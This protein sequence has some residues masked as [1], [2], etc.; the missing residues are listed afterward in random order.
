GQ[1]GRAERG[2]SKGG[3][4]CWLEIGDCARLLAHT[5][6]LIIIVCINDDGDSSPLCTER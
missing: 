6:P 1:T 5:V 2:R 4:R 3:W